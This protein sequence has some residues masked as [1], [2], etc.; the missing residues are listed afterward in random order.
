MQPYQLTFSSLPILA[1]P[2]LTLRKLRLRDANDLFAYASDPEVARHVLWDAHK[3][4]AQSRRFLWGAIR[5][6]RKGLPA[7]YAIVLKGEERMIGTIGFMWV[8]TDH[9]S[10]EIGYSLSREYWNRGIMTEALRELIRFGFEVLLL[11]RIEAQHEIDNP[12]SGRVMMKAGMRKEG[13]MRQRLINKGKK[14]DVAVYAILQSDWRA[15][16]KQ[17]TT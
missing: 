4:L 10:A 5:Q 16:R 13:I 11:N 3:T 17:S 6:Y 7:S 15:Q 14:V 8:N 2:R 9:K 12:A 1:T